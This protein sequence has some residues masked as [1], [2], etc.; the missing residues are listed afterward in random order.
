MTHHV[1]CVEILHKKLDNIAYTK[2]SND[3]TL[4]VLNLLIELNKNR[5]LSSSWSWS[6]FL[7]MAEQAF[8]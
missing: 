2:E 5:L 4:L 7:Y 3:V 1:N 6:S 8:D